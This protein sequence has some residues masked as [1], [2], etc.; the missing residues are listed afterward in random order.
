MPVYLYTHVSKTNNCSQ[1]EFEIE[2]KITEPALDTCPKCGLKVTRLISGGG[3]FKFKE[4]APTA[5]HFSK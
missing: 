2:Q 5:K 1:Q 3:Y 4:G